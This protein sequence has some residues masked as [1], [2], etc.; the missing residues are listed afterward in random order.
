MISFP[1]TTTIL[2]TILVLHLDVRPTTAFTGPWRT[3]LKTTPAATQKYQNHVLF[4]TTK[5]TEAEKWLRM[6]RELRA[7]AEAAEQEVHDKVICQKE[8]R[9]AETDRLMADIFKNTDSD[10][11]VGHLRE[12]RYC[13]DTLLR[14]IDRM[15]EQETAAKESDPVD[16]VKLDR[17]TG[18]A[19]RLLAAT[20]VLDEDF[21][22]DKETKGEPCLSSS[23]AERE[24]WHPGENSQILRS[25]LQEL[26]REND[27]QFKKRQQE[28]Y[29]AQRR[30]D[31]PPPEK[32]AGRK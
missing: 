14:M 3:P 26:R 17:V 6:A 5:E 19:E 11:L 9:R 31:L 18:N 4:S 25:K 2:T 8:E 1:A 12:K 24:H 30:K 28:F 16:Q 10:A 32:K 15:Y 7:E 27:E 22:H 23:Y 21:R 20:A 29:D 13:T